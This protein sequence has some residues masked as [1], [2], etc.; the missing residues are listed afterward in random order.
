MLVRW[1]GMVY[2]LRDALKTLSCPVLLCLAGKVCGVEK[3][4][5]R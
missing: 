1:A 4:S 2:V 3:V 5:C